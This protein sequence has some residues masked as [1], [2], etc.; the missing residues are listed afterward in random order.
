MYRSLALVKPADGLVSSTSSHVRMFSS[1]P[2]VVYN[3]DGTI[4]GAKSTVTYMDQIMDWQD[5]KQ[6]NGDPIK[7]QGGL[8]VLVTFDQLLN[9]G[10][11]PFRI[12]E[13]CGKSPV[14]KAT[15][16]F[17][18]TKS[19]ATFDELNSAKVDSNEGYPI[20]NLIVTIKDPNGKV[21]NSYDPGVFTRNTTNYLLM[22]N[23]ILPTE[24]IPFA[25][26]KNTI[27]ID[28]R[29]STGELINIY[30]GTL[31]A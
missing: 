24:V 10:Y 19:S 6:S 7:I 23:A 3:P 16:T 29:V 21:L 17:S 30:T 28:C 15:L 1:V 25:D 26:G 5:S 13:L 20:S 2:N 8:D 12:P 14:E 4:N 22:G 9:S 27:F 11:I 31:L 18:L